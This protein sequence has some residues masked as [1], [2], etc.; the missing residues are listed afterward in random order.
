MGQ[1][2]ES[3]VEVQLNNTA[4]VIL[5]GT[6]QFS[7]IEYN[8]LARDMGRRRCPCTSWSRQQQASLLCRACDTRRSAPGAI[9]DLVEA[10][11]ACGCIAAAVSVTHL[12]HERGVPVEAVRRCGQLGECFVLGED[13]A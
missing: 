7:G 3:R 4:T 12:L 8:R 5:V 6:F 2:T 11:D 1:H 10:F 9:P 13:D